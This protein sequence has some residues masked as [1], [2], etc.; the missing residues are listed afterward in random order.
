LE[1]L[2]KFSEDGQGSWFHLKKAPFHN[3][4]VEIN[5]YASEMNDT[6]DDS[7]S[8][9]SSMFSNQFESNSKL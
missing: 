2:L 5:N 7:S 8:C 1:T 3:D 4:E 9:K 6:I